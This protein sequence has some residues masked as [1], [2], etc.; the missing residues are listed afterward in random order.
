MG[1]FNFPWLTFAS[2]IVIGVSIL[3]A[4]LWALNDIRKSGER[5]EEIS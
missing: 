2:L 3:A 5:K 1:P 4:I